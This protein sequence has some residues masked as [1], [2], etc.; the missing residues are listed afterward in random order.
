MAVGR[1]T[2]NKVLLIGRLGSDPEYRVAP[3]GVPVVNFNVATNIV[4]RDEQGNQKER[5]DWHRVVVWRKLAETAR[6]F[7]KK[8]SRVY[9]EGH[10]QTRTYEDQNNVRRW[11]TEVVAET[12]QFLDAKADVLGV[13]EETEEPPPPPEDLL[14]TGPTE[15][16]N[17]PF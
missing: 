12:I 13:K 6:Q 2:L 17:I 5:T 1:G 4:W 15:E 16:D 11:V 10:L 7:L 3:N 8:G 9:I 14:P